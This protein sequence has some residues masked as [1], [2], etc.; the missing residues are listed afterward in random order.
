MTIQ[1][2]Y[3]IIVPLAQNG[4]ESSRY[5]ALLNTFAGSIDVIDEAVLSLLQKYETSQCKL[6]MEDHYS[7]ITP[8]TKLHFSNGKTV[9]PE[10]V[11]DVTDYLD[12]R[13][14]LF[15]SY[16]DEVE[17]SSL[18][19]QELLKFHRRAARQ[20]LV[21]IPSY[22]CNLRCPYCWQRQYRMDSPIMTEE[23]AITLFNALPSFIKA[24][25][26]NHVDFVVFGGEPLQ[27][28]A[29][30]RAR[31]IQLLDLAKAAGYSTKIIS[32]GVSLSSYIPYL[33]ERVDVIQVTIDGPAEVHRTSRPLP[34]EK[35]GLQQDSFIPMVEG[36]S[37]AINAGIRIN[38]RVNVS[39]SN[40]DTL[41]EL[42]EF[43]EMQGWLDSGLVRAHL[44]P[45]KNHNTRIKTSSESR[46]LAKIIKLVKR[47]SRL[48]IFELTGFPGIKY[49]TG[50]KETGLFSLH[51]FFNCEAQI[52]F[53]AFDPYGDVYAC[54]DAAGLSHL[55]VGKFYPEIE[56]FPEKLDL[57]RS[58]SSI[59]IGDCIGCA[60]SPHCGGG[61]QFLTLEHNDTFSAASCDSMIEGYYH[62]ICD[63]ADWLLARSRAADHAVGL[64][65]IDG[66]LAKVNRPFGI[67][68]KYQELDELTIGCP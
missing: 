51:R 25:P 40:L 18:I 22:N 46:L 31:V 43:I 2:T 17:R 44:A 67:L 20:P 12:G 39:Q 30:L 33:K 3:N 47:D 27:D 1:S 16:K 36:I 4:R 28:I 41:P 10:C 45:I 48:D 8:I 60:S 66:V 52:N 59:E 37:R 24:Q 21:V 65:T 29:E 68:E 54:W 58:R 5:Y 53:F 32:N 64:I 62:A 7:S 42:A 19:Y 35:R 61:C 55:A 6:M 14:Y 26:P 57:W 38:I 15:E 50:F 63:N 13:G 23:V 49:F 34:P 9:R 11:Q 56:L